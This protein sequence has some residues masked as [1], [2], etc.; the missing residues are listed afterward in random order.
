M[1]PAHVTVGQHYAGSSISRIL[2]ILLCM[3]SAADPRRIALHP[4]SEQSQQC[5]AEEQWL[6]SFRSRVFVAPVILASAVVALPLASPL[7]THAQGT[8]TDTVGCAASGRP[9]PWGPPAAGEQCHRD[10]TRRG[11][12]GRAE[13]AHG[14]RTG[15]AIG[16]RTAMG[17]AAR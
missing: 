9:P 16:S 5:C 7:A 12:A 8:G 10:R 15:D 4:T 6:L 3:C 2:D 11:R 1:I 13:R 17:Y 14:T